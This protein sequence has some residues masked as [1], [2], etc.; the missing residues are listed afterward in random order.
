MNSVDVKSSKYFDFNV[1][2]NDKNPKFEV[3]NHVRPL[4][5]KSIFA[6]G[7]IPYWSE[8]VFVIKKA[9]YTVPWKCVIVD[10]NGENMVGRFYEKKID[11]GKSNRVQDT[12]TNNKK[13]DKLFV[14]WKGY[15][16]LFNSWIDKNTI[17]N[18]LV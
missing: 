18:A 1:E 10:L 13:A 3:F 6:K 2:N 9:N 5:Y 11:Q 12:K 8:E 4:N 16:Y 7:Y 17:M 14:K 15:D